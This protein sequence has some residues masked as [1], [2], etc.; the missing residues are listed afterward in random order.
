MNADVE[1]KLTH[2]LRSLRLDEQMET[3]TSAVETLRQVLISLRL[4]EPGMD[5]TIALH[6]LAAAFYELLGVATRG[7]NDAIAEL[8]RKGV[9]APKIALAIGVER[10]RVWKLARE[11]QRRSGV[12]DGRVG[13]ARRRHEE[14]PGDLSNRPVASSADE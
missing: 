1:A 9:A 10:T 3:A 5:E 7:R 6:R 13:P 11:A 12:A 8:M 14:R 2:A 4:R